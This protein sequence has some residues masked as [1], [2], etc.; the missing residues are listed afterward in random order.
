MKHSVS[1]SLGQEKAMAATR[2]AFTAYKERF[3]NYSPEANWISD[4]RANISFSAKGMSL[5]GSI[6][7]KP[8]SIDMD[9]DVP[10][11]LRPFKDTA[12]GAVEKEI[13]KWVEKAKA[14]EI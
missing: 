2:A 1:H 12:L 14:G 11:F 7:V 13:E 6:E 10:F 8:S 4:S 9:L 3:A 5:K